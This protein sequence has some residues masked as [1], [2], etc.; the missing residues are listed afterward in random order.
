MHHAVLADIGVPMIFVQWP[1]M[2]CALLPVIAIEA[3]VVRKRLSL[4]YGSVRRRNESQCGFD[5]RRRAFGLGTNV[6]SRV[7]NDLSL[8]VG[9][10]EVALAARLASVLSTQRSGN[11]LDRS[12]GDV[13][14]GDCFCD[15]VA[16][17]SHLFRLGAA[18]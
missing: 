10:G 6:D 12:S 11:R 1:L 17:C 9:G 8:N 14:L 5:A 7:R 16:P 18:R 2:I 15:N 3:L 4:S 13:L